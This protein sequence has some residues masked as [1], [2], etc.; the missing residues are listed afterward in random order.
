MKLLA[1]T[2][3]PQ[4]AGRLVWRVV[5]G[6]MNVSAHQLAR[7]KVNGGLMLD[8]RNVHA[9]RR[10][11]AGQVLSV[12]IYDDAP[13]LAVN[14]ENAPVSV[15]YEDEDV[16][17]IDKDAPLAVQSSPRQPDNTLENRLAYRYG[18]AFVF[19]PV[20][21]LDKG[22][23]GLMAAAKHAHAQSVMSAQLHTPEFVREYLALTQGIPAPAQ[24]SIDLPIGKADGAT[25]RREIRADGKKSVTHYRVL[26]TCGA[27]ALVRLR[28]ESGRTHQIRVH[29]SALGCPVLGDFLYGEERPDI[30]PERFALHSAYISFI[31][32]I[33]GKRLTFESALPRDIQAAFDDADAYKPSEDK[34]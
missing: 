9:D 24:G 20:N 14:P 17:V 4:D 28:L 19:R 31:H 23:S 21:R 16:I 34:I 30:L 1:Y 7:A 10:V 25:V 27:L 22:T 5:R 12:A 29:L 13:A 15:V 11:A 32:P 2:V 8:G 18:S 26:K 3:P 6:S 33:S